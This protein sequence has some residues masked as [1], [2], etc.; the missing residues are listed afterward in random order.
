MCIYAA[1]RCI[2]AAGR[3]AP[4]PRRQP[5]Y[6]YPQPDPAFTLPPQGPQFL[7]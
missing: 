5:G 6:G 7:P 4:D 2:T 1:L 3:R